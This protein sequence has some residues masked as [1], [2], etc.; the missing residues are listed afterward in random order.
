MRSVPDAP[1]WVTLRRLILVP[2]R[3][4]QSLLTS[5]FQYETELE[6]L[7]LPGWDDNVYNNATLVFTDH[8]PYEDTRLP[9]LPERLPRPPRGWRTDH[10][11][12]CPATWVHEES[13]VKI[14]CH[15]HMRPAWGPGP[16]MQCDCCF[17]SDCPR[18]PPGPVAPSNPDASGIALLSTPSTF[19]QPAITPHDMFPE[20]VSREYVRRATL[21]VHWTDRL[22]RA[23]PGP[24]RTLDRLESRDE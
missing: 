2:S 19:Q 13:N 6:V 18:G 23:N 3:T 14:H 22:E 12:H 21:R 16:R 24:T 8:G 17:G 5:L 7:L 20:L 10:T 1:A 4:T 11:G 9:D 15:P